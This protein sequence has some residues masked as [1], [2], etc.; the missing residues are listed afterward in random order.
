MVTYNFFHIIEFLFVETDV[1]FF[2]LTPKTIKKYTS[3]PANNFK[4]QIKKNIKAKKFSREHNNCIFPQK[5]E[6]AEHTC[7]ELTNNR[8]QLKISPQG[9][10]PSVFFSEKNNEGLRV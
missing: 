8:F 10:T 5:R 1:H 2:K 4:W 6:I 3:K 7:R 9:K